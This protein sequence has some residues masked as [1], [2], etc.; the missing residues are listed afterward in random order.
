MGWRPWNS[1]LY[2]VLNWEGSAPHLLSAPEPG[3][4]ADPAPPS[5]WSRLKPSGSALLMSVV[6][7]RLHFQ[8]KA[9]VSGRLRSWWM[10]MVEAQESHPSWPLCM[11]SW[12][13]FH[14]RQA[15]WGVSS[16]SHCED[17]GFQSH[18]SDWTP[19]KHAGVGVANRCQIIAQDTGQFGKGHDGGA[20]L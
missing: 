15:S 8:T 17:L 10:Q 7:L 18:Q 13:S 9:L 20:R 19:E 16:L 1:V 14:Y 5:L 12:S 4:V 2:L 6:C 11:S 3:R